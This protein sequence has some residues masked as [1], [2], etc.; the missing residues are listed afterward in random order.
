[1]SHYT[2]QRLGFQI[3]RR[4]AMAARSMRTL[5]VV[6]VARATHA[7]T[8]SDVVVGALLVLRRLSLHHSLLHNLACPPHQ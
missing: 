3:G 7:D 8:A 6:V 2:S 1:M 5:H 4:M